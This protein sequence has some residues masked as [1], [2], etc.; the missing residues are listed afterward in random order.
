MLT[1]HTRPASDDDAET[2]ARIYNQG[3]NERIATFETRPRDPAEMSASTHDARFPYLVALVGPS[4]V[5][6][7]RTSSYRDRDCYAGIAE[8]S[9]Y[10]ERSWRGQGIGPVLMDALSIAGREAGFWKFVSRV[11]VEN[12]ASRTMLNRA[13]FREVGIYQ[14]HAQLDGLWRDVVIVEKFLLPDS[15][16]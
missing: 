9:V 2:L 14:R 4:I 11:F 8:F 15:E 10:I 16:N 6:F 7:A 13:G 3:I 5:G 12:T 1:I